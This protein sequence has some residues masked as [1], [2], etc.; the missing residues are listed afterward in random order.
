M[1]PLVVLFLLSAT[2]IA[3][4]LHPIV[5]MDTGYLFGGSTDGNG[6][7]DSNQI[8]EGRPPFAFCAH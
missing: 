3:A 8:D 7:A 1:K 5:E 4:D 6:L 2:A